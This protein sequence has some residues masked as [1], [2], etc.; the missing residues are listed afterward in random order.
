MSTGR[1]SGLIGHV[2]DP[3]VRCLAAAVNF[4][5]RETL[6]IRVGVLSVIRGCALR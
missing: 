4:S 3:V 2:I 6:L 1:P 5:Q